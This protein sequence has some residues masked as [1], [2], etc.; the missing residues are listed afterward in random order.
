M[1]VELLK[2]INDKNS[3]NGVRKR[4]ENTRVEMY[5]RM[6]SEKQRNIDDL[7]QKLNASVSMSKYQEALDQVTKANNDVTIY[8]NIVNLMILRMAHYIMSIR[9]FK[10]GVKI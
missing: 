3:E 9:F 7:K 1:C 8:K 10:G 4:E 2:N 5:E 6:L